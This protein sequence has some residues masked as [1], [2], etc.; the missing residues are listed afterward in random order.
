MS[1][2]RRVGNEASPPI[3]VGGVPTDIDIDGGRVFVTVR[4]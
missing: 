4:R 2:Q 1:P 3:D